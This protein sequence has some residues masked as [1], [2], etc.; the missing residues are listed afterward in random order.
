METVV[1]A[2]S[3][4][5]VEIVFG[6]LVGY[7]DGLGPEDGVGGIDGGAGDGEVCGLVRSE[8]ENQGENDSE[9]EERQENRHQQVASGGLGK[10]EIGHWHEHSK[11]EVFSGRLKQ[12]K[13][14]LI[15]VNVWFVSAD[16]RC[17]T[18]ANGY[19]ADGPLWEA[20]GRMVVSPF[21]RRTPPEIR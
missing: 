14:Q 6:V 13:L 1:D 2:E 16:L 18:A 3:G 21:G 17:D 11:V 19:W 5:D 12:R 15:F 7:D 8:L 10:L 9:N 4:E 20:E